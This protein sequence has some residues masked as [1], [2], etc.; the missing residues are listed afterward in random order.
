MDCDNMPAPDGQDPRP[1]QAAVA[2]DA[3]EV[4]RDEDQYLDPHGEVLS[5]D[6]LKVRLRNLDESDLSDWWKTR[7]TWPC[8]VCGSDGDGCLVSPAGTF[9]ACERCRGG[10]AW[11]FVL[12]FPSEMP[13]W[14][15]HVVASRIA[16]T[17][18]SGRRLLAKHLAE[19]RAS[20]LTDETI[21]RAGLY[22]EPDHEQI[23]QLLGWNKMTCFLGPAL[24]IPYPNRDGQDAGYRRVKPD[25]PLVDGDGRARKYESPKGRANRAYFPPGTLAALRDPAAALLI[26]EGEKKALK[27]DQEGFP[28]VG[29][30]G[31]WN[32]S[33][34]R[35]ADEA[36]RKVGPR[37]LI[38][39]LAGIA[40]QGRPVYL[41]F[42]SDAVRNDHVRDAEYALAVA[43]TKRGAAVKVVALP[44]GP[45]GDDGEPAKVGLDDYLLAHT[46]DDLRALL[47]EAVDPAEIEP[48]ESGPNETFR[49]PHR[50]A[51][52]FLKRRQGHRAGPGVHFWDDEWWYWDGQCYRAVPHSQVIADVT[53]YVKEEFDRQ[54]VGAVKR[55][56]ATMRA[57]EAQVA[58]DQAAGRTT[59]MDKPS[60]LPPTVAPVTTGVVN[61]AIQAM[62]SLTHLPHG[63]R[64]PAWVGG[65]GPVPAEEVMAFANGLLHWPSYLA[66]KG[67]A[68]RPHTPAFFGVQVV[69]FNFDPAAP[70][71]RAWVDFL[72]QLWPGDQES[73]D[74]LQEVF[75]YLLTNDTRQQKIIALI[76]PKRGGKGTIARALIALVGE[77]NVAG[78][79]LASLGT[80]FGLQPLL[81]KKLAVIS[82]A[83][84]SQRT[85]LAVVAERLL[86]ISGEDALTVN[87]K[88]KPQVLARLRVRFLLLS[89]ELPKL[90]DASGA[91]PSRFL[92]FRLTVS[93]FG[94]E[95]TGLQDKLRAELPGIVL[96]SLEGLR[97]LQQKGRLVQPGAGRP[98]VEELHALA[99]PLAEFVSDLCVQG[100]GLTVDVPLLFGT[101]QAWASAQG[102]KEAH[103]GEKVF[104]R[105][106][107][108]LVPTLER[109]QRREGGKAV[110]VY[111]GLG[112]RP[113]ERDEAA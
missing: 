91:L 103:W 11:A 50:L 102:L 29:L 65:A 72:G 81:D 30:S 43:L 16:W 55:W 25:K 37:E 62:R 58:A 1:P 112:L 71:P 73:I 38:D 76:G 45:A 105:N 21:H 107:R 5:G 78:P 53:A 57:Y 87:R 97:R 9:V 64:P 68:F 14:G 13:K 86:T 90:D 36:G 75:G 61:N 4:L 10:G 56:Q 2:A 67:G 92:I 94:R 104:G 18:D 3:A 93:W 32:W 47:A 77:D 39:D 88:Y 44:D 40:W 52:G 35:E 63:S 108:A 66:G 51:K 69:G 48:R 28:C 15:V 42:D 111:H 85:D 19:L 96:W 113:A 83:R 33:K 26:T 99:S 101:W 82:D 34:K 54:N 23:R 12:G 59:T 27:A 74:A 89:N 22:S 109:K 31:V 100:P 17:D 106:L 60:A 80:D 95:D 98:L 20:G 7:E 8:P 46:A 24:V 41:V 49:D 6:R 70:D 79:T 110:G 84:L